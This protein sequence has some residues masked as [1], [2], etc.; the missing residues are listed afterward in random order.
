MKAAMLKAFGTP[1]TV[2]NLPDPQAAAGEVV[3]D[4]VAAPVLSYTNEVF[5]GA[6]QYPLLLPLAPGVGAIGRVHAVGPDAT[7]LTVGDW[8]FCDPTVRSRDDAI[9]PDVMLQGWI[10]PSAGAQ[11][12]QGYFR[13]GPFAERVLVPM[14]N[15]F[16]L[17]K[18]D[19]ADAGRWCGLMSMLVPYGG[20]LASGLQAG[21]TVL[22]SGATGHFGSAGVAVA[23]AMGAGR[24]VA[25]GRN[26]AMLAELARRFGPR[27]ATVVL[28]GGEAGDTARMR[29][30]AR[31]PVDVV[32]DLLPPLRDAAP[33]RAAAMTVRP[34]GTVVLMG[35]LR[36]GVAFP[37]AHLMR[38]CIT[39]RGQ[40]MYPREAP[41]RLAALIRSGLLSLD[42]FEATRFPLDQVN[43]AVVHAAEHGGPFR[44]T[45]IEP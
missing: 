5:S 22:I 14:E 8:V 29:E 40:Y 23:L 18:L 6:R 21:N 17:G 35:G 10:A 26:E 43:E 13:H 2:E 24:V 3:V 33:V 20:L 39:V 42:G 41:A 36:V 4:V 31:G 11:R 32:L 27:V 30:A 37:Y 19:R 15:A 38:N 34:H 44:I 45:F 12:L 28:S 7:R 25:P 1:L 16:A 9:S